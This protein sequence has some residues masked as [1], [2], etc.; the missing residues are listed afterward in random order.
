M[1]FPRSLTAA[2]LTFAVL[3]MAPAAASASN[4]K[5][6]TWNV[7]GG[8]LQFDGVVSVIGN[9]NP[10]VV[11]LQEICVAQLE[12]IRTALAER[13]KLRYRLQPGSVSRPAGRCPDGKAFGQGMLSK[14]RMTNPKVYKFPK[15][16]DDERRGVMAVT[17]RLGKR[18]VRVYNTHIG[19]RSGTGPQIKQVARLSSRQTRALVLGDFNADPTRAE[20]LPM[21]RRFAE[22][23][24]GPWTY[25]YNGN[26]VKIDYVFRRRV[27]AVKTE[28]FNSPSSDHRPMVVTVRRP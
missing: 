26:L 4:A 19:L 28:V 12:Q 8:E 2:P 17:I 3:V 13:Y 25:D 14:R 7:K 10:D 1:A 24:R 18:S 9:Q 23:P 6:M 22:N 11:G 27:K 20:M 5:V 21:F 16:S 15:R